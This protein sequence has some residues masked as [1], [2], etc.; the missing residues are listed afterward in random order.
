VKIDVDRSR[1][2]SHGQCSLAA[3]EIFALNDDLELEYDAEPPERLRAEAEEAAVMC[4]MQ[5]IT[6]DG[7]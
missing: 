7:R 6:V 3:P 4:P 2:E 1:C 5:A